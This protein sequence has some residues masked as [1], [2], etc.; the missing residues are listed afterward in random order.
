MIDQ[1]ANLRKLVEDAGAGAVTAESA[2]PR[3]VPTGRVSFRPSMVESASA[4]GV[5]LDEPEAEPRFARAIAVTSGKGGVGKSNLAV[6]L[7]AALASMGRRVCL[8]DADLGL[9]NADVLCNLTPRVTLDDVVHGSASLSEALLT[10]PGGFR[11][12]PGASGVSRLADM[13]ALRRARLLRE[14]ARLERAV[15]DLIIDTGAGINANVLGF[16][17]AAHL[18]LLTTTPEPTALTDGYGMLKAILARRTGGP[19]EVIINQARNMHE[20][21]QVFRRLD[22]VSRTFLRTPLRHAGTVL[23][24]PRVRDAVRE[25]VPFLVRYPNC[26]AAREVRRMAA[27]LVEQ[28]VDSSANS[29]FLSRLT[30]WMNRKR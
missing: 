18:V 24:D 8:I 10:A 15:D 9:A 2:P 25:R 1:A 6:N 7:A 23:D 26:I 13:S 12:V 5:A 29:G 16:C 27:A 22:R 4:R 17:A 19:V 3:S 30:R 20:G 28:P 11:L 21:A 14:L